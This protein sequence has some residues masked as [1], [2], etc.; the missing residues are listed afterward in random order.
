[1]KVDEAF[2]HRFRELVRDSASACAEYERLDS[3]TRVIKSELMRASGEK[4][5]AAQEREAYAHPTYA[6]H[7][8]RVAEARK[9]QE[10]ARGEL[11]IIEGKLE[12]LRTLRADRRA[13]LN[14]R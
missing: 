7:L 6:Q 2:W 4:S 8:E 9:R 13:E 14:L 10:W 11:K 5:I 12:W 3:M 1:M